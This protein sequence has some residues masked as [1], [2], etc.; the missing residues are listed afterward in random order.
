MYFIEHGQVKIYRTRN[1]K[2]KHLA[3]LRPGDYFGELSLVMKAE[4]RATAEACSD[5][6]LLALDP[7]PMERLLAQW[8]EL[9]RIV[10]KRIARYDD[11]AE[12]PMPLDFVDTAAGRQ[13]GSERKMETITATRAPL[14]QESAE[15]PTETDQRRLRNARKRRLRRF[16]LVPQIDEADCGAAALAMVCRYFGKPVSLS[17]LRE[18]SNTAI[19]GT[20][21]NDIC[22]AATEIGLIA[23]AVKK[24]PN[25]LDELGLPAILHWDSN[26]WV[27][28]LEVSG[29]RA[30]IADPASR[31]SWMPL[32]QVAEHWTGYAAVFAYTDAFERTP[33][34]HGIGVWLLPLVRPLASSVAGIVLLT[35]AICGTQLVIPWLTQV[36]VDKV[37]FPRDIDK[38]N[39]IVIG[40]GLALI[41]T[42]L[43]T[44]L[45]RYILGHAA[46]RLDGNI[47]SYIMNKLLSLP[48]AYFQSRRP[49]DLQRR[50]ESVRAARHFLVHNS[51]TGLLSVVQIVAFFFMM[52]F[53]SPELT[54][55]FFAIMAP[56]YIGLMYFSGKV[57]RPAFQDLDVSEARFQHLQSEIVKGIEIVKASGSEERYHQ[58]TLDDFR[59][60]L[61]LQSASKFNIFC[62]EGTLQAVWFMSIIL[63]IWVGA[64]LVIHDQLTIGTFIGFQMLMGMIHGPIFAI[65]NLW[66]DLQSSAGFFNTLTDIIEATPEQQD[67]PTLQPVPSLAGKISVRNLSFQYGG[68]ESPEILRDV[69]F[70]AMPSQ[71]IAVV[72]RSGSGKTT[73]MKC[74][75][76]LIE[77]SR[78]DIAY[79]DVDAASVRHTDLRR[80]VGL[81]LND[82]F[83]FSGTV[84]Q[85][86]AFGD[87]VPNLE[88]ITWAARAAAAHDFILQ[89]PEGYETDLGEDRG[90]VLS[91]GQR[92][93]LA[94]ARALYRDP[95]ILILDEATN[96]LDIETE[97]LIYDKLGEV[98][99]KRTIFL[100]THRL[101]LI[102]D[103]DLILVLDRGRLLEQG[104]HHELLARRGLYYH[105][106]RRQVE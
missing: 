1:E 18:L 17:Y 36:T 62:Y 76:A 80:H 84:S 89:L 93:S 104:T 9:R 15:P 79:D 43:L 23:Q 53:F 24:P 56:I 64:R 21:L 87:P 100:V 5:C 25:R 78:G 75:A 98:F 74:L 29:D 83:F 106:I 10:D 7:I 82:N 67:E 11:S 81:V 42:L 48:M 49:S 44:L 30:R 58:R 103:A 26:H 52:A 2:R 16:E 102:A 38:L 33:E 28:L 3:F 66:E 46:A 19:T 12:A 70:T 96:A 85:N 99:A 27:V 65:V 68:V 88:R 47:M 14:P 37:I 69:S 51:G 57:L 97:R 31:V 91:N 61:R 59:Q 94:I 39:L 50:L 8:P 40:L 90:L 34:R 13:A 71:K 55:L 60:L 32:S 4:R 20:G 101:H 45:Q 6:R 41:G 35:L 105:L 92:Q 72:G 63:F 77:P 86:I 22:R 95:A 54:L 73:L